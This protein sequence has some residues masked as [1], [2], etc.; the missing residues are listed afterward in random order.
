MDTVVSTGPFADYFARAR[1]LPV[2]V[3]L[4]VQGSGTNLLRSILVEAFQFCVVQDQSIVFNAAA[5]LGRTPSPDAVHRQF[6]QILTHLQ[7]SAVTRK[8]RQVIKSNADYAGIEDCFVAAGVRSSAELAQFVYA[9]GAYRLG[10]TLMAVKSDDLWEHIDQIDAV[11]PNR[12]IVLLTRDFRDNL[13]SITKKD[14]GPIEPLIA[15]QYVHDRFSRYEA[16]FQRTPEEQ[17]FHVRYEDLLSDPRRFALGFAGH[18]GLEFGAGGEAGLSRLRIRSSNV[19]KWAGLDAETL[20]GCE[21][22]LRDE[23]IRYGYGVEREAVAPTVGVWALARSRD[24]LRRVP[25]KMIK[26]SRRLQK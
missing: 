22:I 2:F 11:I 26:I 14:F 3:V 5:R 17:R 20:S 1:H 18:F 23:L 13:L 8:T 25:Q 15:A 9:Y 19:K 16:E 24:T 7:P 12:R 6:S 21:G 4:G 10:T